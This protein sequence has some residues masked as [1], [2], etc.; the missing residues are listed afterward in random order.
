MP[1]SQDDSTVSQEDKNGST[2]MAR[3]LAKP[4]SYRKPVVYREKSLEKTGLHYKNEADSVRHTGIVS[5][6]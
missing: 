4:Q 2:E 1:Q 5:Q 3:Q 6:R